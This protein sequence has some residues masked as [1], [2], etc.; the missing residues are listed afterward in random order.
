[1][2]V[3]VFMVSLAFPH[4]PPE[5]IARLHIH[6]ENRID[7]TVMPRISRLLPTMRSLLDEPFVA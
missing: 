2:N 5:P 1:M 7:L 4:A 6:D 3:T